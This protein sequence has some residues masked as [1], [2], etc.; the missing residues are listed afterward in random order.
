MTLGHD[1][2]GA[3]APP[4]LVVPAQPPVSERI[5]D[6]AGELVGRLSG[7]TWGTCASIRHGY[8]ET[9]R[10]EGLPVEGMTD[11]HLAEQLY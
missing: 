6:D 3:L 9:G 1:D 7:W 10:T 4:T 11:V 2:V 8:A 5:D